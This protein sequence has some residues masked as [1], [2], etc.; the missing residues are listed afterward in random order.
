MLVNG[1]VGTV[2]HRSASKPTI[3]FQRFFSR[4]SGGLLGGNPRLKNYTARS[5]EVYRYYFQGRRQGRREIEF[6]FQVIVEGSDWQTQQVFLPDAAVRQWE[7]ANARSLSDTERYALAK[8]ALFEAFENSP[9]VAVR[10][11]EQDI[12]AYAERLGW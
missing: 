12:A 4:N 10:I 2:Q 8:M 6:V 9:L 1:Y 11:S 7:R 5:G 3:V